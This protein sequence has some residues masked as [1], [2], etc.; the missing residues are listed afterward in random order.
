[1]R[2]ILLEELHRNAE[3]SSPPREA[4]PVKNTSRFFRPLTACLSYARPSCGRQLTNFAW[5]R[6]GYVTPRTD[7]YVKINKW[8]MIL[9]LFRTE[10]N[11]LWNYP[12]HC[13]LFSHSSSP[14]HLFDFPLLAGDKHGQTGPG[15]W[16]WSATPGRYLLQPP[17]H[18]WWLRSDRR[19]ATM[20][21]HGWPALVST[22]TKCISLKTCKMCLLF[23]R[24]MLLLFDPTYNFS[25]QI[26]GSLACICNSII[27]I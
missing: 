12:V 18:L 11:K 13:A 24:E 8:P 10:R 2:I 1:M 9:A 14:C 25:W 6:H 17:G 23:P 19:A 4:L 21:D 7:V 3:S 16:P 22:N 5:G 15:A 26:I 27:H 20:L